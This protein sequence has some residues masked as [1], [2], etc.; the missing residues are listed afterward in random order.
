MMA[1]KK[2][3][4]N[5]YRAR[6]DK[7]PFIW[8]DSLHSKCMIR[9]ANTCICCEQ[10]HHC[11]VCV[12]VCET[13]INESRASEMGEL[14]AQ[15]AQEANI[16]TQIK[17][18]LLSH[19][20][21]ASILGRQSGWQREGIESIRSYILE[22]RVELNKTIFNAN[23][24][25]NQTTHTHNTRTLTHVTQYTKK[26]K[27]R[28]GGKRKQTT[29]RKTHKFSVSLQEKKYMIKWEICKPPEKINERHAHKMLSILKPPPS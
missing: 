20:D 1:N 2:G 17:W 21:N 24:G 26:K 5:A 22:M 19:R 14:T 13:W 4:Q 11:F 29:E 23:W 27:K 8:F 28:G 10:Q 6:D 25:S 3:K 9:M 16:Y 7:H 15:Q 12:S 18:V